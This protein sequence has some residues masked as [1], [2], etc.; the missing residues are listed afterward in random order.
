MLPGIPSPPCGSFERNHLRNKA[1]VLA[2]LSILCVA[3]ASQDMHCQRLGPAAV[4]PWLFIL[5]SHMRH[6]KFAMGQLSGIAPESGNHCPI[7]LVKRHEGTRFASLAV[8]QT[9][10]QR[11][12]SRQWSACMCR[13]RVRVLAYNP[14]F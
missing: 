7:R 6:L 13:S 9:Q 5:P 12:E 3:V 2:E 11:A 4:L 14:Q 10:L 8:G 1:S